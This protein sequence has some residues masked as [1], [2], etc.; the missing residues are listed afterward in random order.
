MVEEKVDLIEIDGASG[1]VLRG[2]DTCMRNDVSNL[3]VSG[4]MCVG[5]EV[6]TNLLKTT[7]T[8]ELCTHLSSSR[9]ASNSR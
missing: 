9:K 8:K 3:E 4:E 5:I 7:I 2:Y 1:S 6:L